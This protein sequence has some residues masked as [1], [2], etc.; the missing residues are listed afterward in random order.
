[1]KNFSV[2]K[3]HKTQL[4]LSKKIIL[5]DKLPPKIRTIAGVDVSYIGNIG[6]AAVAVYDYDSMRILEAHVVTCQV[7]M[8]YISTLLS[9]ELP[10]AMK[11]INRLNLAPEVL[12][13]DAQGIAHP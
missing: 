1:M 3:V 8:P 11:A 10:P 9:R 5:Q 6:V 12:L 4:C 2:Q 7:K 13:V